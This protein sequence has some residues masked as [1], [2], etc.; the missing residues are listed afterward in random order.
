MKRLLFAALLSLALAVASA[1]PRRE[2][3]Q[4]FLP[5][6]PEPVREPDPNPRRITTMAGGLFLEHHNRVNELRREVLEGVKTPSQVRDEL[7]SIVYQ[8]ANLVEQA[9]GALDEI[10]GV[11]AMS[12]IPVL[13]PKIADLTV[14]G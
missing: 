13:E 14:L 12:R 8:A 6:I 5:F 3:D 7:K 9:Q 11:K 1:R 10:R 4:R 2:E